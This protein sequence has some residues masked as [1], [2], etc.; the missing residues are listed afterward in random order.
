MS[1]KFSRSLDVT[2][3]DLPAHLRLA[4]RA[5][6][7]AY[8]EGAPGLGKS[9]IVESL[10][11]EMFPTLPFHTIIGSQTDPT[12]LVGRLE[13]DPVTNTVILMPPRWVRDMIA[14]GGGTV[15][16]DEVNDC[17]RSVM[18]ALQRIVHTGW[19][20]DTK[21]PDTVRFVCAGNAAEYS[22]VGVDLSPAFANRMGM[23]LR[24][25]RPDLHMWADHM[26]SKYAEGSGL[27]A[28][29]LVTMFHRANAKEVITAEDGS[30]G[31]DAGTTLFAFPRDEA[32]RSGAWASPRSWER[33]VSM[34]SAGFDMGMPVGDMMDAVRA[35]VGG[36]VASKFV[37]FFKSA[38]IPDPEALL[39]GTV[40]FT[41]DLTRADLA[42]AVL[43]GVASAATR[44]GLALDKA[45]RAARVEKA[46]SI[47][48][49]AEKV[50]LA[51]HCVLAAKALDIWRVTK[52]G[53]PLA[54]GAEER[55]L[56]VALLK[57]STA[58]VGVAL[59]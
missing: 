38:N 43:A 49:E 19:V 4:F 53:A 15:F 32:A 22:T 3:R 21:L 54:L 30:T 36:A 45:G 39:D 20:G 27:R 58:K 44:E 46:W 2:M 48:G 12:E 50:G 59:R 52:S 25:V 31:S 42:G 40:T 33:V 6:V 37:T 5:N 14:A 17:P 18:A 56:K 41:F 35:C 47:V 11:A 29:S 23:H 1:T 55:R 24:C 13:R 10:A 34:L 8:V 51:D 7:V 57:T 28:A 16:V 9:A 26:L